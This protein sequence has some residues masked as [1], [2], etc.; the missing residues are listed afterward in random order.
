[1]TFT[2]LHSAESSKRCS[3]RADRSSP[4][5]FA[6]RS[7]NHGQLPQPGGRGGHK[8]TPDERVIEKQRSRLQPRA[9]GSGNHRRAGGGSAEIARVAAACGVRARRAG[10]RGGGLP[11]ALATA[12]TTDSA[13]VHDDEPIT[14]EMRRTLTATTS[15]QSEAADSATEDP[16]E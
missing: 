15:S 1:L 14:P 13:V 2:K 3:A 16:D 8:K 7:K 4:A 11:G 9:G 12:P 5:G 6:K 10:D